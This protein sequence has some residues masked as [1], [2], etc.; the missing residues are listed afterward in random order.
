MN[1]TQKQID[2][3]FDYYTDPKIRENPNK[4]V[5]YFD[6]ETTGVDITSDKIIEMSFT[7]LLPKTREVITKTK[8]INPGMSIPKE[9]SDVHGITN[10]DVRNEP[11][12]RNYATG[13]KTFIMNC[14]LSGYNIDWFDIPLLVR[15]FDDA[16][17]ELNLDHIKTYDVCTIYKVLNPRDLSAAY[18][19]YNNKELQGAHGAEADNLATMSVFSGMLN[20]LDLNRLQDVI[21]DTQEVKYLDCFRKFKWDTVRQTFVFN[22]GKWKDQPVYWVKMNKP[23][24]VEWMI[25]DN[26]L[27]KHS[28]RMFDKINPEFE[29][30]FKN[31]N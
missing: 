3:L 23:A 17:I 15:E 6:L 31:G 28:K 20:C 16:G 19:Q 5:V 27:T 26:I 11:L 29:K 24:Y 7:K 21:Q 30:Q 10:E 8:R 1:L 9:A 22:F 12:F 13:I 18:R 4:P 25:K 14:D 2:L